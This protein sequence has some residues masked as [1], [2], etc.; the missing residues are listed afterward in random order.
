MEE[1]D[2][3]IDKAYTRYRLMRLSMLISWTK[4]I[5]FLILIKLGTQNY[6]FEP[7]EI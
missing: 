6:T 4:A 5:R 3:V 7:I 2:E 1:A